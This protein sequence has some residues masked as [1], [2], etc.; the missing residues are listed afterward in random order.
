MYWSSRSSGRP[1]HG[2]HIHLSWAA[3]PTRFEG[4]RSHASRSIRQPN[5]RAPFSNCALPSLGISISTTGSTP[6][7]KT[8]LTV[9]SASA[10]P[11]TSRWSCWSW[12]GRYEIEHF[13]NQI[14]S[15][16]I[17]LET[18]E[19]AKFLEYKSYSNLFKQSL[20]HLGHDIL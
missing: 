8:L 18:S 3:H 11:T 1:F 20:I 2:Q 5:M 15:S 6:T 16:R 4:A 9:L 14:E 12:C 7:T 17:E 13:I 19:F 10:L